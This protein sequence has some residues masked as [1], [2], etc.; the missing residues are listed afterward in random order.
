M[1]LYL[2]WGVREGRNILLF[3]GHLSPSQLLTHSLWSWLGQKRTRFWPLQHP[4]PT[5]SH[6]KPFQGRL[7][8]ASRPTSWGHRFIPAI[9]SP[10]VEPSRPASVSLLLWVL[11]LPPKRGPWKLLVPNPHKLPGGEASHLK[12]PNSPRTEPGG[13]EGKETVLQSSP[14]LSIEL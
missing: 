6:W 3:S 8:P 1:A 13:S 4:Y 2:A 9:P 11:T 14:N 10:K 5:C 12:R 7:M